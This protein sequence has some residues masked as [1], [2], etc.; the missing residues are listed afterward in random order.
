[1]KKSHPKEVKSRQDYLFLK[2]GFQSGYDQELIRMGPM[3][4]RGEIDVSAQDTFTAV[5]SNGEPNSSTL[6]EYVLL[7]TYQMLVSLI[8]LGRLQSRQKMTHV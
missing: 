5:L 8:Q 4:H 6:D 3:K 1:M 2:I 7:E